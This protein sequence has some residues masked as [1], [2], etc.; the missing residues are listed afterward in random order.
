MLYQVK[1]AGKSAPIQQLT[2]LSGGNRK[3]LGRGAVPSA[4]MWFCVIM[5]SLWVTEEAFMGQHEKPPPD[6]SKGTPPPNNSDG[7][8]PAPPPS[9]GQH[10]KDK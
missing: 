5:A 10:K 2:D 6:P 7:Q 3:T 9:N 1:S 4:S 8:V